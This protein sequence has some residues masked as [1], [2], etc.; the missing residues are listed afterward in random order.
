MMIPAGSQTGRNWLC[1][2][3]PAFDDDDD[4]GPG[5]DHNDDHGHDDNDD[6]PRR[7]GSQTERNWLCRAVPAFGRQS[8]AIQQLSLTLQSSV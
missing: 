7:P 3:V 4:D 5:D 2:A 8:I 1:R 6:D